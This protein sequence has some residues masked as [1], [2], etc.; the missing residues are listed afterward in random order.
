MAQ[1]I[2]FCLRHPMLVGATV[3][4]LVAAVA[5]EIRLR[6]R[7][8]LSVPPSRAIELI[9]QGATVVDVREA[10]RFESGHIVD[11][12]NLSP[13]ELTAN[14]AGR[15]KKKRPVLLV[16]DNG[17]GSAR[18][19]GALRQAGFE[20]AWALEGGLAAWLRD[21]LPVV[22]KRAKTGASTA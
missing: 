7:S 10:D 6:G 12:L 13:A 2:E 8:G 1:F 3:A 20:N 16:C 11:A 14:A 17:S 4:A 21:K 19:V 15:L 22:T 5:Y 9:N 18:L